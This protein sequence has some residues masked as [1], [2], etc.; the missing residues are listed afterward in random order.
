[1]EHFDEL[2][3]SFCGVE[4]LDD[5]DFYEAEEQADIILKLRELG[6]DFNVTEDDD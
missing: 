4:G 2:A 6:H 5:D 3:Y 1:M